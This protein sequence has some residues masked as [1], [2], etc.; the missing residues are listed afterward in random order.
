MAEV[1]ELDIVGMRVLCT[2]V[3]PAAGEAAVVEGTVYSVNPAHGIIVLISEVGTERS[4]FRMLRLNYIADIAVV[5]NPDAKLKAGTPT[6]DQSL[7]SGIAPYATLP[8]LQ[9]DSGETLDRKITGR[10]RVGEEGRKY[11][12]V[13][14]D[15]SIRALEILDQLSRVY[16][17]AR[18]EDD[19]TCIIVGKD[20][21]VKGIP[22]WNKPKVK[23]PA[24]QKE[25]V[26]RIQRTL[27]KR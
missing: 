13:D 7:P 8:S 17:D 16:P 10:K 25:A 6:H 27:D 19:K 22:S 3:A 21:T 23:G 4:S 2:M 14:D 5:P 18:W 11:N 12:G 26:D 1:A 15:V 20:I 24:D 9:T